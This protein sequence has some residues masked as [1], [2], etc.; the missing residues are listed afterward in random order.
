M[1][2]RHVAICTKKPKETA[3][4][5]ADVFGMEIVET[6]EDDDGTVIFCSDGHISL[7]LLDYRTDA[8]AHAMHIDGGAAFVGMHHLGFVSS[9]P[10][11]AAKDIAEKGQGEVMMPP[12]GVGSDQGVHFEYKIRDPNGIIVDLGRDWPG[13]VG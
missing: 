4:F 11:V 12:E 8:A 2:L 1:Q 6:Q 3:A 5:Y 10:D 13:L 7:A 9:D